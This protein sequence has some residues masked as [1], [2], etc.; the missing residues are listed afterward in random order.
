MTGLARGGIGAS[1]P[2]QRDAA[3]VSGR[4]RFVADVSLPGQLHARVVRSPIAH[5][6]LGAIDAEAARALPGVVA[7]FAAA[8]LPPGPVPIRLVFAAT[9]ESEGVLQ[10]L[11]ARDVVRYV[12]EPIALVVAEDPWTAEDAAELVDVDLDPLPAVAD[13]VRAAHGGPSVHDHIPTNVINS[14]PTRFGDVAAASAPAAVRISR[15]LSVQ[16]HTAVPM[17]TRGLVA[18]YDA[19]T[20]V[21][22][23]WGAAKVKHFNRSAIAALLELEPEQVRLVEVDVGGGFGVRGEL[24]PEDVLIPFAARRLGRPVKWIEDRAEHLVATNHAREQVHE[25]EVTATAEGRLLTMRDTYWCD[26]G[27]YVRTQGILPT[28][29]PASHLP[30]PY[31]WEAFA[32]DA[33]AVLT[34]RTPV[35]TYRGPG[36]TEATF[37]RE[38][39]L[40][41]VAGELGLDP[42]ELRRRNLGTPDELPFVYDLGPMAPPIVYDSGDFPAFFERLLDASGYTELQAERERRRAAGAAV[43]IGL[44][45]AVELGGI[46]PFEEAT[47]TGLPDGSFLVRSGVGSLGQGVE[48]VVAQIAADELDVAVGA[49]LVHHHDTADVASGFGSFAS[50]STIVAG[51]AVAT[52]TRELRRRAAAALSVPDADVIFGGGHA[53]AARDAANAVEL[54]TLGEVA[55]RFEKAHPSFSFGATLS[56]VE[57]DRETGRVTPLRHVVAHDVG[58]AVNPALVR[59]QLVGAAAQ[60]IAGALYEELGYDDE[61]QPLAISLADYLMPTLAELPAIDAVVIEH[62]V[63]TNPLGVK[64]AGEGG[65]VGATAAVANAVA[66]ALSGDADVVSLP[67][68]PQ[69]VRELIRPRG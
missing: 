53:R 29:L 64:G 38:R 46:G 12:G 24:Y 54:A 68:T 7:V 56:L 42:A 40:D 11:L 66:D 31:R 23:V 39:M 67:L 26:Q 63:T 17:E 37:V 62:E 55:G 69:R 61:G 59:G 25:I 15:R 43:G 35:G 44:A 4:G 45:A 9:P 6:R 32:I 60:G 49:V 19:D 5:A 50:R 33:H 16:R 1:A 57:V 52:A 47:I 65:I 58:R 22:T 27:A 2:R 10:P 21:L 3:L 8:D 14:I 51:N 48:T 34:H 20:G 18:D 36:M 28:L 13:P 30:G 41:L